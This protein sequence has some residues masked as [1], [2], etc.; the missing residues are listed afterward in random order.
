MNWLVRGF[1]STVG[2]KMLVAVSGLLLLGFVLAHM[3]GNLQVF[4][5]QEQ[6]NAY[7]KKLK[8]LGPVLWLMRGGLLAILLL[9]V[10]SVIR[11]NKLNQRARP[12]AYVQRRPL[13]STPASRT[14][15]I[16]G[17]AILLFVVYHLLHFT[18]GATNPDHFALKDAAGRHDVYSM[19]VLGFQQMHITAIY[20]AAMVLLG[21]H[22]SHG[23][24][25][26]FQTLGWN[27][28]KYRKF[29]RLTGLGLTGLIVVGNSVM[30][31]A[32]LFGIVKL[33]AGVS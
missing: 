18:L 2:T 5:G 20:V 29:T 23:V 27:Q 10:G 7:A 31:L 32:C 28:P 25:S 16:S 19:V 13:V 11:L 22:L 17:G 1:R 4:A 6:L 21:L 9:H 8:G 12:V 3:A 26:L 30:P 24:A 15:L 14:M 33:P